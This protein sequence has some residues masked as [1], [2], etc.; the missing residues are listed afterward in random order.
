MCNNKY[1]D[2]AKDGVPLLL[3]ESN[4]KTRVRI[5][6][7]KNSL[8][9]EI[10]KPTIGTRIYNVHNLLSTAFIEGVTVITNLQLLHVATIQTSLQ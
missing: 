4:D 1:F 2:T 5:I 3:S 10:Q 6:L 7:F 9:D 8:N